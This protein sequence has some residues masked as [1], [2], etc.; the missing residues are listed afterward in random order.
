MTLLTL[1]RARMLGTSRR[2][3]QMQTS[4]TRLIFWSSHVTQRGYDARVLGCWTGANAA[5][6]CCVGNH[7]QSACG[8]KGGDHR[9][10]AGRR[11]K[12]DLAVMI[13]RCV[14]NTELCAARTIMSNTFHHVS[15]LKVD[16]L[17][18]WSAGARHDHSC[19]GRSWTQFRTITSHSRN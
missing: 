2:T 4:S 11:F 7:A 14:Y 3:W 15:L 19:H 1:L 13:W 16:T 5:F 12:S 10:A 6:T 18:L 8:V 9:S 17:C